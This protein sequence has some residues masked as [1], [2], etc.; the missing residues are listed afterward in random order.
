MRSDPE[1]VRE[2]RRRLAAVV[3]ADKVDQVLS[4]AMQDAALD[5][6][7]TVDDQIALAEMLICRRGQVEAVGRMLKISAIFGDAQTQAR[8]TR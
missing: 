1:I 5:A 4:A 8:A 2:V 3:G 6:L 7:A